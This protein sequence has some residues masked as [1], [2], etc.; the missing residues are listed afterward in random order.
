MFCTYLS[1]ALHSNVKRFAPSIYCAKHVS[2]F[3]RFCIVYCTL[4]LFIAPEW[5]KFELSFLHGLCNSLR[6]A[7]PACIQLFV[8]IRHFLSS[9]LAVPGLHYCM[10]EHINECMASPLRKTSVLIKSEDHDFGFGKQRSQSFVVASFRFACLALC[11]RL[12]RTA[13]WV[14]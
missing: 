5:A 13:Q 7:C 6:T 1:A 9:L 3:A 12:A 14:A 4:L 10:L 11:I 2:L 8:D